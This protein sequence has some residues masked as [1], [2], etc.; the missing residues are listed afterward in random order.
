MD[1][2]E[3]AVRLRFHNHR[4]RYPARVAPNDGRGSAQ[5]SAVSRFQGIDRE[6]RSASDSE[7]SQLALFG[8]AGATYHRRTRVGLKACQ[9]ESAATRRDRAFIALLA[10]LGVRGVELRALRL[11]DIDWRE[12]VIRVRCAK[13]N[14]ERIL[15]LPKLAGTLLADY[16]QHERPQSVFRKLFLTKL[17]PRVPFGCANAS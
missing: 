16:I 15:P 13:T 10:L 7:D 9:S 14:R 4:A 17:S 6:R 1:R 11:E 3:R 12:G 5:F 8:P 2:A